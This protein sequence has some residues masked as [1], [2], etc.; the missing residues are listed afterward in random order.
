[1]ASPST[2]L[3]GT[4]QPAAAYCA[5]R[6]TSR[7]ITS[8][9]ESFAVMTVLRYCA[10]ASEVLPPV[11]MATF[12]LGFLASYMSKALRQTSGRCWLETNTRRFVCAMA[13]DAD[14]VMAAPARSS[15]MVLFKVIVSSVRIGDAGSLPAPLV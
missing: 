8:S 10:C 13:A 11:S 5:G 15:F 12:T 4:V 7:I 6:I 1:L 3:N 9:E 2:S 14:R